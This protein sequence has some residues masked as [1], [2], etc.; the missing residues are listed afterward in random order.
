M[1]SDDDVE[2]RFYFAGVF[3]TVEIEELTQ[4]I[5]ALKGKVVETSTQERGSFLERS[6]HC[7]IKC[8]KKWS[9]DSSWEYILS[10]TP[11]P[12][13]FMASGKLVL[14][15]DYIKESFKKGRFLEDVQLYMPKPSYNAYKFV[16]EVNKG[17]MFQD[18]RVTLMVHND[19]KKYLD[20]YTLLKAGGATILP[21]TTRQF[22]TIDSQHLLNNLDFIFTEPALQ[23]DPNFKMFMTSRARLKWPIKVLS[24]YYIVQV[25]RNPCLENR[26]SL[27]HQFRLE[28]S[29]VIELLHPSTNAKRKKGLPLR[30]PRL[31]KPKASEV[32]TLDDSDD[33]DSPSDI[34]IVRETIVLVNKKIH[35]RIK[36]EPKEPE[37]QQ[38]V[39]C[40]DMSSDEESQ[41]KTKSNDWVTNVDSGTDSDH[42]SDN[43]C[44]IMSIS[45]PRES[46]SRK[47]AKPID[48]ICI[49]DDE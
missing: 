26:A 37:P 17:P 31:K 12:L 9:K 21:L 42:E 23:Q 47:K 14:S 38:E 1:A 43:E 20:F 4:M 33:D 7:L 40:L 6:T 29:N 28:N 45:K 32:V 30:H 36:E 46:V 24:F 3:E 15:P 18:W 49:S 35:R 27:T 25:I 39:V 10:L 44:Q 11:K 13:A 48:V 19:E 2:K 5:L 34:Q 41:G 8:P 22:R 16:N